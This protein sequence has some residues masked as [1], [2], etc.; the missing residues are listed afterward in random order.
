[1]EGHAAFGLAHPGINLEE[2]EPWN[3]ASAE[4]HD[5]LTQR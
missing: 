3:G 1:M 4:A 5:T 2:I